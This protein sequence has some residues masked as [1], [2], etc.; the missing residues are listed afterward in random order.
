MKTELQ[1]LLLWLICMSTLVFQGCLQSPSQAGKN[2][3]ATLASLLAITTN[4]LVG[5]D[6]ARVNLLCAQDLPGCQQVDITN[7]LALLDQWVAK[8]K[9]EPKQLQCRFERNRATA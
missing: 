6:I 7:S 3:P 9:S 1:G 8:V 2:N 5:M 4:E